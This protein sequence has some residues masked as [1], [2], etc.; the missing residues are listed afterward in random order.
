MPLASIEFGWGVNSCNFGFGSVYN[1][2]CNFL[3]QFRVLQIAS[4]RSV[5]PNDDARG[6]AE[7]RC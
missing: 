3:D 4:A 1:F 6:D 2:K 5:M 7:C